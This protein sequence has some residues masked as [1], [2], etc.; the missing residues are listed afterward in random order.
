[1]KKLLKYMLTFLITIS[2]VHLTKDVVEFS[3]E[4]I[5]LKDH[6]LRAEIRSERMLKPSVKIVSLAAM[7]DGSSMFLSSASGFSV[8]Y[9]PKKGV[10]IVIT[11]D[12]FCSNR[13]NIDIVF[14]VENY[15]QASI[16]HDKNLF[17]AE[18]I[19]TDPSLDL[20]ALEVEGYIR[21]ANLASYHYEP[22]A[23]EEIYIVGSPSGTYP[24]IIDSYVSKLIDRNKTNLGNMS[25]EGNSVI[26]ISEQVF[27]GHSGSPVFTKSGEVIG[28]VFGALPS[29]GGLA[30]SV[31][32]VYKF[33]G[34]L[35]D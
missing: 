2:L 12:H 17:S 10:S 27:P 14:V 23:F 11:N 19:A 8:K 15:Q 26:M 22:K 9:I 34:T 20:C 16:E 33:L 3:R 5:T 18:V 4:I 1:M 21:P 29:Y 32:D 28:V 31:K 35:D 6:Q 24:I 30:V 25:S 7:S 13:L